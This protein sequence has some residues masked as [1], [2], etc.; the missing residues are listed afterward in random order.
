MLEY[1]HTRSALSAAAKLLEAKVK[2]QLKID[3]TYASG[4][5]HDSVKSESSSVHASVLADWK[6]KYIDKGAPPS[7]VIPYG[8]IQEWAKAKGI[9]P[10][11]IDGKRTS[12]KRM[13]WLIAKSISKNGTISRFKNRGGGSGIL[14]FVLSKQ[15]PKIRKSIMEAYQKDLHQ[16]LKE[17]ITTK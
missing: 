13:A 1:L 7:K 2:A 12:F 3:K 10:K 15:M 5:I 6:M 14:E 4:R 17:N 16:Y 11:V 8:A 9:R